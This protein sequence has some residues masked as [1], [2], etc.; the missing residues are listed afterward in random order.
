MV[1]LSWLTPIICTIKLRISVKCQFSRIC[2]KQ[3][4]SV[5]HSMEVLMIQKSFFNLG[6]WPATVLAAKSFV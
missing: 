1:D 2:Q 5:G 6:C 4:T 3:I